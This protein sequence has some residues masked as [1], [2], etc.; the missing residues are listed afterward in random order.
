MVK[1]V[2][3][4]D[5]GNYLGTLEVCQDVTSVRGLEGQHAPGL[6]LTRRYSPSPGVKKAIPNS[7]R[8]SVIYRFMLR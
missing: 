1:G 2:V 5:K 4:D 6:G 7:G 8:P 3:Q